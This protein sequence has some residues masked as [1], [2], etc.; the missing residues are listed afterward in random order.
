MTMTHVAAVGG[1]LLLIISA[2]TLPGVVDS[3]EREGNPAPLA[4]TA[5]TVDQLGDESGPALQTLTLTFAGSD[6]I[7]GHDGCNAFSGGVSLRFPTI[8]I[9]D[10]LTGT[11]MACPDA[12]ETRARTYRAA[13][14]QATRY[15]MGHATL[16]L[17]DEAGQV[18][19]TLTPAST[20]LAG[21]GWDAISYN[22]GKQAVV[23]LM[24]G[25]RISAWFG[26]DGRV[27]GH[28]GCNAY[29]AGYTVADKTITIHQPGS[30]RRACA[31]PAGVMEQETLYLQALATATQYRMSGIRLELRNAQGSLVAVFARGGRESSGARAIHKD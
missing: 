7:S 3:G 22:N 26:E 28:A 24:I 8:H 11:M 29:F 6:G 16:E 27:T 12:V 17:T 4:D 2:C 21:I 18:L 30:T 19:V 1:L 31:E 10:K 14:L 5:W 15:H 20:S 9:A 23:S 25:T 13:L